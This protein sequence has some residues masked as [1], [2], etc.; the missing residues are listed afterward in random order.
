MSAHPYRTSKRW[1]SSLMARLAHRPAL[2]SSELL[3]LK[4]ARILIVRQHNQMGDMVC[5]TPALRAIKETFPTA[6]IA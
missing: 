6:E 4:P 2:T 1:L 3:A 5:A